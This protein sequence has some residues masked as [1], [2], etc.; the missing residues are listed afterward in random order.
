MSIGRLS[1]LHRAVFVVALVIAQPA[2]A[3]P[4]YKPQPLYSIEYTKW[5]RIVS[6]ETGWYAD[7]MSIALDA[8]VPFVNPHRQFPLGLNDDSAEV[9]YLCK[10]SNAG[11]A[12]DPND[13][14]VKVHQAALL[15]A[16]VAGKRVRL[17]I[18]G[19]V[20]DKPRVIAV[21]ITD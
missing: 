9:Q 13:P 16:F 21:G 11:Y 3:D 7:T 10:I 18:D 15:S 2:A 12:L 19:C 1:S 5:G 14:G 6:L 4:I 8:S 17:L 20:Y